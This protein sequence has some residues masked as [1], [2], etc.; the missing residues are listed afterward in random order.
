MRATF[1]LPIMIIFAQTAA[2]QTA[3]T[4]PDTVV[5]ATRNALPVTDIPAG[6]TVIDRQA[7]DAGCTGVADTLGRLR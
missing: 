3:V 4:I 1:A 7:I 5:T 6:V 2:A